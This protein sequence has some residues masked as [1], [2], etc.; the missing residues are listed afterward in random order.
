MGDAPLLLGQW[1]R[2]G[3]SGGQ[4]LHGEGNIGHKVGHNKVDHVVHE[5]VVVHHIGNEL[6]HVSH[7]DPG[8]TPSL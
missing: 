7:Q 3:Y 4:H 2:P 6:G 8:I 5:R 1:K